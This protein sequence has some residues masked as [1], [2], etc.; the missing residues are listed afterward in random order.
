[1]A[2][3]TLSSQTHLQYLHYTR[4]VLLADERVSPARREKLAQKI[5][6]Y[7]EKRH[8]QNLSALHESIDYFLDGG[9]FRSRNVAG[10]NTFQFE[11][12]IGEESDEEFG[13]L[14]KD[15]TVPQPLDTLALREQTFLR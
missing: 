15:D 6:T 9:R 5:V 1:M 2:R 14:L 11:H 4:T 3:H 13:D 7:A 12:P 10:K 8:I